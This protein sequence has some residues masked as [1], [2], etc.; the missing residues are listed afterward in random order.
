MARSNLVA[1]RVSFMRTRASIWDVKV[2]PL[3]LPH[4]F[5]SLSSAHTVQVLIFPIKGN[6]WRGEEKR[7]ATRYMCNGT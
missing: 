3:C 1:V 6:D 4:F 7:E 2:Y 5:L